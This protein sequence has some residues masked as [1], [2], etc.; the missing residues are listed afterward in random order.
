M[1]VDTEPYLSLSARAAIL[2]RPRKWFP[3]ESCFRYVRETN[4]SHCNFVHWESSEQVVLPWTDDL[5]PP[6]FCKDVATVPSAAVSNADF[7]VS[8]WGSLR[9]NRDFSATVSSQ[10]AESVH[11]LRSAQVMVCFKFHYLKE[12]DCEATCGFAIGP[13]INI[14]TLETS[15]SRDILA[16][17]ERLYTTLHMYLCYSPS[18]ATGMI[19]CSGP[20]VSFLRL[21]RLRKMERTI[22]FLSI[23]P[24]WLVS[25]VEIVCAQSRRVALF[26]LPFDDKN[27]FCLS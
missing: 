1:S 12:P 16:F 25:S 2:R 22:C 26:V 3:S 23:E 13:P 21:T 4:F 7:S 14:F 20:L 15:I 24:L 17:L 19:H 6:A 9:S 27:Y 18:I 10:K 5:S 8:N 11:F